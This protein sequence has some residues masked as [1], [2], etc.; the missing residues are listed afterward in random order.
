MAISNLLKDKISDFSKVFPKLLVMGDIPMIQDAV[1][2]II[3]TTIQ[4]AGGSATGVFERTGTVLS[5][6]TA[7]DSL[8][9]G[10]GGFLAGIADA[11]D[12]VGFRFDTVNELQTEGS[13][14]LSISNGGDEYLNYR[15]GMNFWGDTGAMLEM[16]T[17]GGAPIYQINCSTAYGT[18]ITADRS[19]D[20]Y[21]ASDWNWGSGY[22]EC[23]IYRDID[24]T[25]AYMNLYVAT[26]GKSN[27]SMSLSA[28]DDAYLEISMPSMVWKFN[29]DTL[30]IEWTQ[31][32]DT[33]TYGKFWGESA[34]EP[35]NAHSGDTYYDTGDSRL[36]MYANSTWIEI[37]G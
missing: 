11:A 18:E 14:I 23:E 30:D 13:K 21:I 20:E 7:G 34:D 17:E 9:M 6:T 10:L 4:E 26:D 24:G 5:P 32:T 19:I 12:A 36:Y 15:L 28:G 16:Y 2:D 33:G 22:R 3:D 31:G 37:G 27:L 35:T 29:D 8:D 1:E 25:D